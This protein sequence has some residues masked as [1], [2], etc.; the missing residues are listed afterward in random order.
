M[1]T[2]ESSNPLPEPQENAGIPIADPTA[3]QAARTKVDIPGDAPHLAVGRIVIIHGI[4][5]NGTMQHPAIVTRVWSQI[6]RH[7]FGEFSGG[8]INAK[9]FYD[10]DAAPQW[11]TQWLQA[12]EYGG[13]RPAGNGQKVWWSWPWE[14]GL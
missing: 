9:V 8:A 1:Q 3:D 7:D 4:E 14:A 5:S 13:K 12:V 6:T 11:M 10:S 2:A